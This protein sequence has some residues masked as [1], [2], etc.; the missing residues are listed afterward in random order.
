M[1]LTYVDGAQMRTLRIGLKWSM[2]DLHDK[3][4]LSILRIFEIEHGG[5]PTPKE[6][7]KIMDAL[8]EGMICQSEPN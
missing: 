3:T 5:N 1:Q 7:S 2:Q 6:L 4:G 8:K